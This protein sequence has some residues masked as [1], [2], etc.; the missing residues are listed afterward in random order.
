MKKQ[1]LK[2]PRKVTPRERM[3]IIE[4]FT[5]KA[6]TPGEIARAMGRPPQTVYSVLVR[7]GLWQTN[8][9]KEPREIKLP[10]PVL[11]EPGTITMIRGPKRSLW[12][13]IKDFFA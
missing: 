5:N 10:D 11:V 8:A 3:T 1:Y 12:Q 4:L 6:G 7:A 9:R 2:P 13:R